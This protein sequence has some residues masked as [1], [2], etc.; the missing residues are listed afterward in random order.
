MIS[1][2]DLPSVICTSE[3][4]KFEERETYFKDEQGVGR[5]GES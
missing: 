1:G 4:W 2:K 3:I 5:K